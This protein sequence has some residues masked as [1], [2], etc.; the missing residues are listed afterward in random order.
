MIRLKVRLGKCRCT[1]FG[2]GK[3]VGVSISELLNWEIVLYTVVFELVS[4]SMLD[5]VLL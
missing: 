2:V 3:F 5:E 4:D 1:E